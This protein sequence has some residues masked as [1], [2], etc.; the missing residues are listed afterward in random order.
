VNESKLDN[1]GYGVDIGG[2]CMRSLISARLAQQS[3]IFFHGADRSSRLLAQAP[4]SSPPAKVRIQ[5]NRVADAPRIVGGRGKRYF[6]VTAALSS[7]LFWLPL[8][9]LIA[10]AVKLADGGPI[11]Y[12]HRR[13][14]QNGKAYDCFKF[15]TMRLDA[16]TALHCHLAANLDAAR[17]WQQSQKLKCDPRITPLG[18]ALRKTSLDELPQ[19]FNI[20]RGEMSLVGPRPIVLNEVPKYG[21][22]ITHYMR[23]RPGLTGAWQISGRNDVDYARR[24]WLDTEYVENWSFWRDLTIIASTFRVVLTSRGCY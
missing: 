14:G 13:V 17:E 8:L 10:I 24:V 20:V 19:L 22:C 3:R 7:I 1:N 2:K 21:E 18:A 12:R 11:L 16:D 23:A 15:R 9:C 5:Q 4:Q 6:D